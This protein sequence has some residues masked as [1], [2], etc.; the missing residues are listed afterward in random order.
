M[1]T[2]TT[3]YLADLENGVIEKAPATVGTY[4]SVIKH[5]VLRDGSIIA[6][7]RLAD[8]TVADVRRGY[9]AISQAGGH[10]HLR[11]VRRS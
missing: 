5:R 1:R 8:V 3:A 4:R 6:D 7:M 2:A 9:R 10:S 11:H